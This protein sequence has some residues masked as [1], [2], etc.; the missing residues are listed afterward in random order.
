MNC[1]PGHYLLSS[2]EE[3]TVAL[4]LRPHTPLGQHRHYLI[5]LDYDGTLHR[6]T[7]GIE[8]GFFDYMH[9]LRGHGVLWGINT[10]RSLRAL[11]E[12]LK[13]F[14]ILPDFVC[15]CERYAYLAQPGTGRLTPAAEHNARCH[16]AN[17]ALREQLLPAWQATLARIRRELPHLAWEIAVDD[18]LS[19][20][21]ADSAT[22][23]A[24]MPYLA[25][26]P[27]GQ[28]AAQRAGRFMRLSDARYTKGTALRYVQQHFGVPEQQLVLMGDGHNDIDAFRHFPAAFCAAPADAHPDVQAWLR[29]HGGHISPHTGVLHA[30]GFW[31]LRQQLPT[32]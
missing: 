11:A 12:E 2:P 21:A 30:L 19:I 3:T 17:M 23:D 7:T 6:S 4:P 28:V 16:S 10:G 25:P 15:T 24:L 31:A 27:S 18:P 26:Q 13:N 32:P 5:S 14:P 20:E 29:D 1:P 22:M 9:R 8:P